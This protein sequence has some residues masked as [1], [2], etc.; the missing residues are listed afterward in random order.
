MENN[1]KSSGSKKTQSAADSSKTEREH[2]AATQSLVAWSIVGFGLVVG[3]YALRNLGI[4]SVNLPMEIG[5]VPFK[6]LPDM[7]IAFSGGILGGV[8][9]VIQNIATNTQTV[10]Q[11]RPSL[12]PFYCGL[13]SFAIVAVYY[14]APAETVLVPAVLAGM[15]HERA[16]KGLEATL[17]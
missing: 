5:S 12:F 1:A 6:P 3:G 15:F 7:V 16:W 14:L 8:F 9:R 10:S 4:K 17:K 2:R 11:S 13:L